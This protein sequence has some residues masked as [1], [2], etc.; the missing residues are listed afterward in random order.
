L[1]CASFTDITGEG[2]PFKTVL[3]LGV[4]HVN[5]HLLNVCPVSVAKPFVIV[6]NVDDY[7]AS[8]SIAVVNP[9][10]RQKTV[11]GTTRIALPKARQKTASVSKVVSSSGPSI[12]EDS[13]DNIASSR[14]R[15]LQ[16]LA[17][18]LGSTNRVGKAFK[19]FDHVSL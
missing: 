10:Q 11:G 9:S 15:A 5:R 2:L 12:A 16:M 8:D 18:K 3:I 6:V 17:R 1:H 14:K 7:K 13:E 4:Q 19:E